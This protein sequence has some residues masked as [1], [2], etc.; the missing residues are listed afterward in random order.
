MFWA[1]TQWPGLE[2]LCLV[3]RPEGVVATA[4]LTGRQQ[5]TDY[6]LRYRIECGPDWRTR[7]VSVEL[8]GGGRERSLVLRSDGAGAWTD[9][10]GRRLPQ[11]DGAIDI[12][13][14]ATPFTNTL[15]IR[16]LGLEPGRS[17]DVRAAWVRV[18]SLEVAPL[19]QRYTCLQRSEHG[20]RWRYD[21]PAH[22]FAADLPVDA[23]GVVIDYPPYFERAWPQPAGRAGLLLVV[24]FL[25]EYQ[26]RLLLM[27]RSA[28]KDHA[29]GEWE[30]GSGRLEP[31]ES[32][33]AAL[34]R[35]AREETGLDVEIVTPI[36]TFRFERGAAQVPAFGLSFHCRAVGGHLTLSDEHDAARWIA[37]DRI[38]D[39]DVADVFR[40]SIEALL[41]TRG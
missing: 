34:V 3:E 27:R 1:S 30:P 16:R 14:A 5:E 35:E 19:D 22:G 7:S 26:G 25:I 23:D 15:P 38:L 37:L 12:D 9:G 41:A 8:R 18:P 21:S 13:I 40:R 24:A 20:A 33:L 2:H 36:D 32:P 39:E 17:A 31:G 10:D 28:S 4:T 11:V 29:S 6:R